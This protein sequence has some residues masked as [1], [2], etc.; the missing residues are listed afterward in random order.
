MGK[1]SVEVHSPPGYLHFVSKE[2][3]LQ[4]PH[5][6]AVIHLLRRPHTIELEKELKAKGR[7]LDR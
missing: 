1:T 3:H 5:A 4:E 7:K 2:Q 6:S